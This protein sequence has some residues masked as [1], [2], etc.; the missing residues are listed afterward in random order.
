MSNI[1]ADLQNSLA[2]ALG[3][4]PLVS[5]FIL[6]AILT[7]SLLIALQWAI[8]GLSGERGSDNTFLISATL[9]IILSTIF[10]WFPP[11]V[12]IFMALMVAFVIIAPFGSRG[13]TAG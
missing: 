11:W 7:V 6:G 1:F 4:D 13:G 12:I 10:G 9:G 5:G 3:I 8:G 2:T